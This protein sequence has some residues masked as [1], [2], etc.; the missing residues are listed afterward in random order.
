M[1]WNNY[2][3]QWV[4]DRENSGAPIHFYRV[5][6]NVMSPDGKKYVGFFAYAKDKIYTSVKTPDG[7][8]YMVVTASFT[9]F[10][11]GQNT[12]YIRNT[13]TKKEGS[14]G[15]FV[16][17]KLFSLIETIIFSY[18]EKGGITNLKETPKVGLDEKLFT[19]ED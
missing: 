1:A 8:D 9:G 2:D 10:S 3:R 18:N 5:D 6:V 16:P 12:L 17:E 15:S 7:R 13:L 14:I 11:T 19:I 4:V